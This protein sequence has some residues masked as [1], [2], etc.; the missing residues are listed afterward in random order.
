MEGELLTHCDSNKQQQKYSNR[1]YDVNVP[2][3]ARNCCLY[4]LHS[5]TNFSE[6]AVDHVRVYSM[7]YCDV[8]DVQSENQHRWKL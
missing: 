8:Y 7:T 3:N 2:T 1:F 6:R 4:T 5:A